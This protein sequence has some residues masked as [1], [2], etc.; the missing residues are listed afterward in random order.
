[1]GILNIIDTTDNQKYKV[2]KDLEGKGELIGKVGRFHSLQRNRLA[3]KAK[4]YLQIG[5][6]IY[7]FSQEEV[8]KEI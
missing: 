4:I 8:E 6:K 5:K 3:S 7:S 2:I 1:M